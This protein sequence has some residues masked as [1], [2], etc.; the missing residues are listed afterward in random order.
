MVYAAFCIAKMMFPD[1]V[2]DTRQQLRKLE[3]VVGIIDHASWIL[4]INDEWPKSM[5]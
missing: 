4:I 5:L 2:K 3:M 1:R